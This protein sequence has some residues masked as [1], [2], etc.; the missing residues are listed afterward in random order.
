MCSNT[1]QAVA[2]LLERVQN[3]EKIS[4]NKHERD[5]KYLLEPPNGLSKPTEPTYGL[6]ASACHSHEIEALAASL[7]VR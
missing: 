5:Q 4:Y 1:D 3:A 7:E 2:D 6:L